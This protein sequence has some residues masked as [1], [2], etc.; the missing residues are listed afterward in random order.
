MVPEGSSDVL[1]L[2]TLV[3]QARDGLVHGIFET[4]KR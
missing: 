3:T 2:G 4:L 1:R